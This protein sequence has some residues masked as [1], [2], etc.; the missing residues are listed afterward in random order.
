MQREERVPVNANGVPTVRCENRIEGT[1]LSNSKPEK[2]DATRV[3][4]DAAAV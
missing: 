4:V 3:V 1:P 2:F